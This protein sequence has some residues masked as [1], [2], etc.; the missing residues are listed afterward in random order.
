MPPSC[1]AASR[2]AGRERLAWT[3]IGLGIL[4]WA[5]GEAYYTVVLWTTRARRSRRRRTSATSLCRRSCWPAR[6]AP[7][8][9]ERDHAADAVGGRLTAALAVSAL[10]AAL[11][12]ET[13]LGAASAATP[14]GVADALAYPLTD[15]VMLG[16]HRRRARRHRLA[17]W[18]ARWALLAVGIVAFWLADSLYLVQTAAGRPT[19]PAAGSTPAGGRGLLLIARRRLAAR[20]PPARR[21]R[22]RGIRLIAVPLGFGSVG[23]GPARLRPPRPAERAGRR[24]GRRRRSVAVMVRLDAD[25]PRERRRCCATRATRR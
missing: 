18:T 7:A 11:V 15:M 23:L 17:R 20:A 8:R 6:P 16:R 9:A 25:L 14:L 4:G 21:A 13:A 24:P 3:L 19:R 5:L 2:H 10:S 22:R 12:F 1:L